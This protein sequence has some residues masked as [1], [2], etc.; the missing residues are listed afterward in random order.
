MK[1]WIGSLLIVFAICAA[2][3]AQE[4]LA[5]NT[6]AAKL[7]TVVL[8]GDSIR[9][10]YAPEVAKQLAGQAKVESVPY[11][12]NDSANVLRKIDDWAIRVQ[13]DVIHFNCGIHD[14]KKSKTTGKFQ[15]SPEEYEKNLRAIVERLRKETKAKVLFALTTPIHDERAAKTRAERD[16]ELLNASTEQYNEI[17]MRVMKELD[18][19][20]DDLRKPLGNPDE[21][22]R[23]L[24]D[25]GV[26][27]N[28][29]G[30]EKLGITVAQF[31]K[32]Y[33]PAAT[34][35]ESK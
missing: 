34:K 18:V 3:A 29:E 14:T 20:V 8:F 25:D 5:K 26:H 30:I 21:Q 22:A 11:N 19:P 32:Q 6:P 13:P 17:A 1:L 28:K 27:L 15:V 35:A 4:T 7:P 9:L 24:V 16:Y 31:V 2:A 12:G 33:L 10:S 23:Y